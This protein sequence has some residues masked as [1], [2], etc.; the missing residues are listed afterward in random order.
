MKRHVLIVDDDRDHA[1]S[2]A[3]ILEMR[4]HLVELA[5]TGEDAIA[6]FHQADFDLVLMDVQL[7]GM[8]GVQTFFEFRK[9][10]PGANVL[11]MTGYSVEQLVTQAV[12]GGALGVIHKPFSVGEL[13]ASVENVKPRGLVLVADDDAAFADS[14]IG[15]LTAHGYTVETAATGPE[16]IAKLARGGIDCLLLDI[17]LPVLSGLEVYQR[18]KEAGQAVPT[19]L[20][21]GHAGDAEIQHLSPLTQGMLTKPFDPELLLQTLSGLSLSGL[22]LSAA[23]A[24]PAAAPV[25][26]GLVAAPAS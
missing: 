14:M 16:A 11:M 24:R 15:M 17:R 20:V 22:S 3:E 23:P 13:I 9:Q 7:P 4:G 18:M 26:A 21:T 12:D 2:L 1:E 8:N 19:I 6:R 10:R 25:A 5:H